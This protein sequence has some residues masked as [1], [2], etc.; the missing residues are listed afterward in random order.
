M[1][2][3]VV[4]GA[5]RARQGIGEFV[6]R[7]LHDAGA[8]IR[9]IVGTEPETTDRAQADLARRYGIRTRGYVSLDVALD[10][11]KPDIVA[12]C[13]PIPT[14]RSQLER[15]A[16][17]GVHCL[18]EKPLWW[19]DATDRAAE[20]EALVESFA[21]RGRLLATITQWPF[22]LPAFDRLWPDAR[23][24][25]V[26]RFSMRL[27]P[28]SRGP[29]M[30]LDSLSHPIS[31]LQAV[32]GPGEIEDPVGR[33]ATDERSDIELRFRYRHA[34]GSIDAA[35]RFVTCANPPRPASY[36]ID[37]H[38]AVREVEMPDYRIRFR[39]GDRTVAVDDPVKLLVTDFLARVERG[40]APDRRTLV[41]G[42]RHLETL[43]AAGAAALVGA[44]PPEPGS[45]STGSGSTGSGSTGMGPSDTSS[46]RTASPE[47][48]APPDPDP[49]HRG[50]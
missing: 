28:I 15:A 4:I 10:E 6:T 35:C 39:A 33:F 5:R 23:R 40:E 37:G 24:G 8:E 38:E 20:T 32:A 34:T 29:R 16:E 48:G 44:A 49:A 30:L 9:G 7:W 43:H 14:H 12:I 11:E 41:D 19:G 25:P 42:I 31:L 47:G 18:C 50:A 45:S 46:S 26:E 21:S 36:A 22:T 27:S 13:S 17:A 1:R 3:A 2:S